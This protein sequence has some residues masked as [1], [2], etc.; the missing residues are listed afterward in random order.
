MV[1]TCELLY[2]DIGISIRNNEPERAEAHYSMNRAIPRR[3]GGEKTRHKPVPP[4]A[5]DQI[6]SETYGA[7]RALLVVE[8]TL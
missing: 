1:N 3:Q 7:W 5:Y 4:Q 2:K 6:V 8:L